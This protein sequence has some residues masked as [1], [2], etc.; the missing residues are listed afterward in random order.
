MIH[1][2]TTRF[3]M[4]QRPQAKA[5][6]QFGYPDF[7]APEPPVPVALKLSG[8]DDELSLGV[9]LGER[10]IGELPFTPVAQPMSRRAGDRHPR[11]GRGFEHFEPLLEPDTVSGRGTM[12]LGEKYPWPTKGKPKAVVPGEPVPE[13]SML[14]LARKKLTTAL[15]PTASSGGA[16]SDR[17]LEAGSEQHS[18]VADRLIQ[19]MRRGM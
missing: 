18:R 17:P 15:R 3:S 4:P 2:Q 7:M 1:T 11:A 9:W 10:Q 12:V 19:L 16:D 5:P 8:D 14:T 13:D 6:L